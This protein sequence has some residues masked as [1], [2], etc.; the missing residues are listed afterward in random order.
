MDPA[1]VILKFYMINGCFGNIQFIVYSWIYF[2]IQRAELLNEL[3]T[4][5]ENR[6]DVVMPDSLYSVFHE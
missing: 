6:S 2:I 3:E 4:T 1:K 5:F